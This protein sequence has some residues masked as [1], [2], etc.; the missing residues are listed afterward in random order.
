MPRARPGEGR[1]PHAHPWF[2]RLYGL[3]ARLA[4]KGE[5][6]DRRRVLLAGAT[7][8][9]L[10]L[11]A[12]TGE[13]FKH[14]PPEVTEVVAVE[15]DP[16]MRRQADRRIGE[17]AMKVELV[18]AAGERLPFEMSSFDTV[19][20]TLV[21]CSVDDPDRTLSELRRVLSPGGRLLF[22]EHVR[23]RTEGLA[24]W[25]DRLERPWMAV[26]GGCHPNRE[27]GGAIDG[28]GFMLK[29][30]ETFDLRSSLPLVRPHVQGSA[31]VAS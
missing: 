3:L 27:T 1:N 31:E 17:A 18:D 22:L 25:Q 14:Y 11:G 4:E 10:D 5:L 26:G 12:G 30:L 2:A 19:V 20:A 28:N 15:P 24:T 29:D 13:N 8:R 6:G 21:L 16:H 7:G 9:V 23:A